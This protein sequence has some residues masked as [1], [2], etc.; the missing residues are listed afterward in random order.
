M[1]GFERHGRL[2]RATIAIA[3]IAVVVLAFVGRSINADVER[4]AQV[5]FDPLSTPVHGPHDPWRFSRGDLAHT[6]RSLARLRPP[7]RTRWVFG[8]RVLTE[9]PP[10]AA[11]GSVFIH[12]F[13]GRTLRLSADTGRVIWQRK[14]GSISASSPAYWR[15]RL[16]VTSLSREVVALRSRDG[17]VLWRKRLN[18]RSESSPIVWNGVLFF[19][20]EGG[21][22]HALSA[23]SG[24]PIWHARTQG[25]I[26]SSPA[27]H[28]GVIYTG[29]YSGRM[30]A[31]RARDGKLLWQN[32]TSGAFMGLRHGAFYST[33]AVAFDRVYVGNTDGRVYAFGARTGRIAWSRSTA[34]RIYSS[35]A[36]ASAPR[37]GPA[38]FV[39][40]NDGKL[41][42]LDAR[43]GAVRW[44]HRGGG[45]VVGSPTVIGRTVYYS[46][47]VTKQTFGV[48]IANGKRV[49]HRTRGAYSPMITDG[50]RLYM[51]GW[52]SVTALDPARRR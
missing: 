18:S 7:F 4:S 9:F 28:K 5:E 32:T 19:G 27:L 11:S 14:V 38:V 25:A 46:D 42:A 20:S 1:P 49:F 47:T 37:I 16:F 40:S 34:G 36:L 24:R 3:G 22:M 39:G 45:R 41:Y 51:T 23:R 15:G 8:E 50:R 35:P 6:G 12:R 2:A 48:R 52:A 33:P 10:I 44:T 31:F 26:K 17:R 43:T 30:Y 13:D 21:R 29:D